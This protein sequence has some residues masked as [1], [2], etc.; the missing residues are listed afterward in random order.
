MSGIRFTDTPPLV[1]GLCHAY[2]TAEA[3]IMA[4]TSHAY[5]QAEAIF[6]AKGGVTRIY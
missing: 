5:D 3:H 2:G 4:R 1:T 6:V